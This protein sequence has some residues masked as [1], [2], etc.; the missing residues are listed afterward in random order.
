MIEAAMLIGLGFLIALLIGLMIIPAISRR[1]DRLAR[2]RAASA[3]PVSLAEIEAERDHLRA[4]FAVRRQE[5][6]KQ[7]EEGFEAR[8][9]ALRE[10]GERDVRIAGLERDLEARN[11][12]IARLDDDLAQ[13]RTTL[14]TTQASLAE[15]VVQRDE[16]HVSL[17]T[18]R[19]DIGRLVGELEVTRGRLSETA[20]LLAE[21]EESLASLRDE[22]AGLLAEHDHQRQEVVALA[23][24]KDALRINLADARTQTT[25]LEARNRDLSARLAATHATLAETSASLQRGESE[26]ERLRELNQTL[27]AQAHDIAARLARQDE[28]TARVRN[29]LLSRVDELVAARRQVST[30]KETVRELTRNLKAAETRLGSLDGLSRQQMETIAA[31]LAK[32]EA[33][34]ERLQSEKAAMAEDLASA[35]ADRARLKQELEAMRRETERLDAAIR[36]DNALLRSE[37]AKVA[38]AVLAAGQT[39]ARLQN[40]A[41]SG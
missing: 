3:F 13:T 38:D 32:A 6:E 23:G 21:R 26:T 28:A 14:A 36:A 4:T 39:T 24:E 8:A 29:E 27:T 31:D 18:A 40:P 20:A 5:L 16:A 15:T 1:A 9:A 2:K 11:R 34:I 22:H 17:A 7:A 19:E 37:I 25:L 41:S 10:I 33:R 35:R 12:Q 30:E